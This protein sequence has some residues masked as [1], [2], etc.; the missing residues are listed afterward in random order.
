[1]VSLFLKFVN[2][3]TNRYVASTAKS[4]LKT[5]QGLVRSQMLAAFTER[6][7]NIFERTIASKDWLFTFRRFLFAQAFA[8]ILPRAGCIWTILKHWLFCF[9]SA[10]SSWRF[11][12]KMEK[13]IS[14][15]KLLGHLTEVIF[16]RLWESF[17]PRVNVFL[18]EILD[19]VVLLTA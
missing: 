7:R 19:K 5:L 12:L 2:N 17:F 16:L 10:R 3:I 14:P 13:K 8:F 9:F 1:M 15:I 6:L 4:S 18:D 11:V